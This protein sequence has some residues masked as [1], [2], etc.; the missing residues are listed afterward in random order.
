M[1]G[2]EIGFLISDICSLA[3][4][5]AGIYFYKRLQT[6]RRILLYYF[7][8]NAVVELSNAWMAMHHENNRWNINISMLVEYSVF[9]YIL[10]KWC[11]EIFIRWL[12]LIGSVCFYGFWVAYFLL[13]KTID[14]DNP[15]AEISESI[16]L[17]LSAGYV[18]TT[19]G[20]KSETPVLKNYR[21][22]FGGCIFIYFSL[23]IL[24]TYIRQV[25]IH[26]AQQD[27]P[28]LWTIHTVLNIP[29]YFVFAYAFK[30]KQV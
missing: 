24:F 27:G 25:I 22:W 18:I 23:N 5:F 19:L 16:V 21:F 26:E 2:A 8:Y 30:M 3:P 29:L 6:D 9:I 4:V 1:D 14:T 12:S 7:I 13:N 11:K 20:L 10:N 17:M 15:A 28:D